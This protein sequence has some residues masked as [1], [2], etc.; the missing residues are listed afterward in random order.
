[1]AVRY[2]HE[3]PCLA[4]NAAMPPVAERPQDPEVASDETSDEDCPLTAEEQYERT[5]ENLALAFSEFL[6]LALQTHRTNSPAAARMLSNI[7]RQ[8]SDYEQEQRSDVDGADSSEEE[9]DN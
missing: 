3:L 5:L 2:G 1:M 9:F 6:Y 7:A 8:L 4:G